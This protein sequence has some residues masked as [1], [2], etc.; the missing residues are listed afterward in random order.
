MT[1]GEAIAALLKETRE[2][3]ALLERIAAHLG[4]GANATKPSASGRAV[5]SDAV[6][7]DRD[8]DS[9][10]GDPLIRKDPPRWQGQSYA[11]CRY[12]QTEPQYLEVMADFLK[13]KAE[14]PRDGADP[15]YAGYDLRDAA[16]ARGWALRVRT[17][18]AAKRQAPEPLFDDGASE[19]DGGGEDDIPF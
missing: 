11:G 19:M 15:K 7:D 14:N 18:P 5:A 10:K 2:N 4:I 13:W 9:E 8:L 6:A 16:R 12:S 3:R 17:K 1:A